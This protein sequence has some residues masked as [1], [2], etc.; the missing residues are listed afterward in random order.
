MPIIGS[1]VLGAFMANNTKG[2]FPYI[3]ILAAIPIWFPL[4]GP[5]ASVM[6]ELSSLRGYSQGGVIVGGLAYFT[7]DG[8]RGNDYPN[9]AAFNIQDGTLVRQY[10][11]EN[12]NDSSPFLMKNKR[13]RLVIVAHEWDRSRS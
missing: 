1:D 8:S 7:A 9:V 5:S 2:K 12:T 13:G 11:F 10:G 6:T 4:S 3:G